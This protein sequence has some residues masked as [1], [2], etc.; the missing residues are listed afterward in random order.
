M[1]HWNNTASP[2]ILYR[3]GLFDQHVFRIPH[4]SPFQNSRQELR[5]ENCGSQTSLSQ[6]KISWL[7]NPSIFTIAIIS[8][9]CG[10]SGGYIDSFPD[11][12]PNSKPEGSVWLDP[13]NILSKHLIP[14]EIFVWIEQKSCFL[15]QQKRLC[16][17][18]LSS[19]GW[20]GS[21]RSH[22]GAIS[23]SWAGEKGPD[24]LDNSR[25]KTR[26]KSPKWWIVRNFFL[27]QGNLGW[28]IH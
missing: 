6:P 23:S 3:G 18:Y 19:M 13:K 10:F 28:W 14:E 15:V 7:S 22:S 27:F 11:R 4:S 8:F 5:G 26:P 2:W 17:V 12:H 1:W 9:S 25:P 20:S 24:S 21:S 16:Q